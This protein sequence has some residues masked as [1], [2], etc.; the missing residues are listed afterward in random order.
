MD[1]RELAAISECW[2]FSK[3]VPKEVRDAAEAAFRESARKYAEAFIQSYFHVV[4]WS[5]DLFVSEA[6]FREIYD[7][8]REMIGDFSRVTPE[9]VREVILAFPKSLMVFRLIAGLTWN[10]MAYLIGEASGDPVRE[11]ERAD[12]LPAHLARQ[13]VSIAQLLV[14]FVSGKLPAVPQTLDPTRVR[15]RTDKLDTREGWQSVGKMVEEGASYADVLYLR[16]SA[17]HPFGYFVNA[18]S[19]QKGD[20]LEDAIA[21]LLDEEGIPYYRT[22]PRERIDG[23][24]QAPDFFIP[25]PQSALVLIEAKLAEDGGTARDKASRIERLARQ[26]EPR[27]IPVIAVVD[28]KGFLRV[29]DVLAPILRATMGLTFSLQNLDGLKTAPPLLPFR[30]KN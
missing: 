10:E 14:D 13:V 25:N 1:Q 22:K 9:K 24:E 16:Y 20:I 21:N 30:G 11:I 29:N 18:L 5:K 27:G 17:G 19:E 6:G 15:L 7:Q 3:E 8:T 4:P 28:G 12:H 26:M 23:F 2:P